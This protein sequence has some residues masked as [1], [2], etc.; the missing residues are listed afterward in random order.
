VREKTHRIGEVDLSIVVRVH[1]LETARR[2]AGEKEVGQDMDRI[3]EVEGSISV[4][5]APVKRALALVGPSVPVPVR[6]RRGRRR[7]PDED[8]ISVLINDD[9]LGEPIP[10]EVDG[11]EGQPVIDSDP[12]LMERREETAVAP[13]FRMIVRSFPIVSVQD[14]H[15]S[16]PTPKD[17]LRVI[18]SRSPSASRSWMAI[19]FGLAPISRTT[20]FSKRPAPPFTE[21]KMLP[22]R[23]SAPT[24]SSAPSPF[25]SAPEKADEPS[26]PSSAETT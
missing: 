8:E 1:G 6:A 23:A 2:V 21:M 5:V 18:T 7:V 26:G 4:R 10:F 20:G 16:A 17:R 12:R 25:R 15:I 11:L 19:A 14:G 3:G 9:Q 13:M 24:T 22:V